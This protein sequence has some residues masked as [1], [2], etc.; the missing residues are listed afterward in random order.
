MATGGHQSPWPDSRS[1]QPLPGVPHPQ[2]AP[3]PTYQ[4]GQLFPQAPDVILQFLLLDPPLSLVDLTAQ[5]P[6]RP[7]GMAIGLQQQYPQFI[8]TPGVGRGCIEQQSAWVPHLSWSTISQVPGTGHPRGI[9]AT[10]T[11]HLCR[12]G[13]ER[14]REA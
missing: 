4:P 1:P 5:V 14:K 7:R 2:A 13:P 9:L 10:K 11:Q 6:L 3:F 12:E 8:Q